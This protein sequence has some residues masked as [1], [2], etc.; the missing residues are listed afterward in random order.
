MLFRSLT[1]RATQVPLQPWNP[2]EMEYPYSMNEL[3]L[4]S[5]DLEHALARTTLLKL[6]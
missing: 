1:D 4:E 3:S 2:F 5:P 6:G